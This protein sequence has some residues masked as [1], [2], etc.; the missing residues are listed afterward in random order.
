MTVKELLNEGS[1]VQLIINASDLKVFSDT[2]I[3]EAVERF[4]KPKEETYI[5][6]EQ[7]TKIL[8]VQ[9]NTLW[10]WEKEN[11]LVPVRFGTKVRYKMSDINKILGKEW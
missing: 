9:R 8:H 10:R 4:A 2:L 6:A 3:N 11:Y 7:A 5:T 1:N